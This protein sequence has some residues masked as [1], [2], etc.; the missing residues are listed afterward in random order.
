MVEEAGEPK[1]FE[2]CD[3]GGDVARNG[4]DVVIAIVDG[5]ADG[6]ICGTGGMPKSPVALPRQIIQYI[7]MRSLI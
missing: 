7:I 2:I 5:I 3:F 1:I 6:E 4:F